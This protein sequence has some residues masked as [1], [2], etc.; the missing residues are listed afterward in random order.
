MYDPLTVI[1]AFS[2]TVIKDSPKAKLIGDF[3]KEYAKMTFSSAVL[4]LDEN[5]LMMGN[6][7]SKPQ[8]IDI[9][10]MVAPRFISAMEK[11]VDY[12]LTSESTILNIRFPDANDQDGEDHEAL[13]FIKS[14]QTV[15][16]L[17]LHIITLARNKNSYKLSEKFLPELGT[18]LSD[19]IHSLT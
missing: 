10:E 19:L 2:E 9:C 11:M 15:Q 3:L 7:S 5:S 6:Y 12:N 1:K 16:G 13:V 4:L 18:Q 14:I 8:Y 17:P